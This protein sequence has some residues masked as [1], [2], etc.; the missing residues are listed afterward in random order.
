MIVISEFMDDSAVQLLRADFDVLHDASLVERAGDLH[1]AMKL[2]DALIVRNRTQVDAT[3]IVSGA[4]LKVVGRLGVGLDNIDTAACAKRGIEVIPATG[5]N[6][7]SVAEYVVTTAM[8]LLRGVYNSSA[9]VAAGRWPRAQLSHG[10]ELRDKTL[11][12]IGFGSIGRIT[13]RLAHNL[14]MNVIAH[15][16]MVAVDDAAWRELDVENR[17]L[18]TLLAESDIV[19]LH[20]PLIAQTRGMLNASRIA[21]M[22]HDAIVINSARGGIVEEGAVINALRTGALGGAALDVFEDEPLGAH[23]AWADVPN[24]ILTPH[25]AGVTVEANA[26]VSAMIAQRV[27][28]A[29]HALAKR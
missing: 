7:V 18:E 21:L 8:M 1:A 25:V 6:A 23:A 19:S 4:R 27:A 14:G 15:D 2:A 17:S 3:L 13:A 29:L 26:R 9:E 24:L 5:A 10:R 20:V 28:A 11:G 22:K 16:P 12:L